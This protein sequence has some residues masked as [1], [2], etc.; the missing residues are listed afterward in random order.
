[1]TPARVCIV[2]YGK[3]AR[4]LHRPA[5]E[6][7]A[8]VGK[9]RVTTICEPGADG[10]RFA[11]AHFPEA[12]VIQG[13]AAEVLAVTD[14]D[15]VD[16]CTPG[17]THVDLA[18]QALQLG[19]A[20]V[21]EK[22]LCHSVADV[23]AIVAAAGTVPVVVGQTLRLS[24]PVR[25]FVR[26]HDA[27]R[28]GDVR[29]VQIV[30][31]ARHAL[32]EGEWVTRTRADGILFENAIHAID[33]AY[34]VMGADEPLHVEAAKFYETSHRRSSWVWRCSCPTLPAGTCRST[35]SRTASPTAV[36]RAA[37][38]S[39]APRPTPRPKFSPSGFRL[40]SGVTD[41]VS[42]LKSEATRLLD[43]GRDLARPARRSERH[44]LLFEDLLDAR[45]SG[46]QT[47][48]PPAAVRSTIATCEQLSHLWRD[49]SPAKT[50][51]PTSGAVATITPD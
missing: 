47:T 51:H 13:D 49:A 20:T 29:R 9:A 4:D 33:L 46:R 34:L 16:I 11:R 22:P 3:V 14:C 21:V 26:A 50:D 6:A 2:G 42:D 39:R 31:H 32:S 5:W 7:L 15:V 25:A 41:P 44:R 36:S 24:P 17:H 12:D 48:I 38:L 37:C 19:R 8:R 43:V 1:M 27:G 18:I 30:H 10:V 35:S 23:D 40:V 28:V 45:L